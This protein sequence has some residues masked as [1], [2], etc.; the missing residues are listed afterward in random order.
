MHTFPQLLT[1]SRFL[2][3]L[4]RPP[5]GGSGASRIITYVTAGSIVVV[6]GGL[7]YANYDPVFKL[8]IDQYMPGFAKLAD[9]AADSYVTLVDSVG[10]GKKKSQEEE[11]RPGLGQEGRRRSFR[12]HPAIGERKKE[13]GKE[14]VSTPRTAEEETTKPHEQPPPPVKKEAPLTPLSESS[15]GGTVTQEREEE[16]ETDKSLTPSS[17]TSS[18]SPPPP[19]AEGREEGGKEGQ[20]STEGGRVEEKEAEDGEKGKEE[21]NSTESEVPS[22][23][24]E[25]FWTVGGMIVCIA[26]L[27]FSVQVHVYHH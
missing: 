17:Q 1:K 18:S 11:M 19:V 16:E 9:S 22:K 13:K 4:C 8:K 23:S 2:C 20:V 7:A 21:G 25:V 14:E 27:M 26:V 15:G 12:P 24:D 5:S 10:L 6:G 3:S